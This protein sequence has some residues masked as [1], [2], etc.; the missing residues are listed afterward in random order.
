M[1]ISSGFSDESAKKEVTKLHSRLICRCPTFETSRVPNCQCGHTAGVSP[2]LQ[3]RWKRLI[4]DEGHVSASLVSNMTPFA[5]LLSIERRWVVTGTP[6]TN[7][8]GLSFGQSSELEVRDG[9]E[10]EYEPDSDPDIDPDSASVTTSTSDNVTVAR[11]WTQYDREDLR[12]L[13]NMATHFVGIPQFKAEPGVFFSSVTTALFGPQ[14]LPL[15]G[16]IQ[17]LKQVMQTVMIRHR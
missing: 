16:A 13:D 15:P 7:L 12:K 3:V 9:E 1:T 6:T 4:V 17:V 8:L 5:Q 11:E 14:R 10:L 2:L